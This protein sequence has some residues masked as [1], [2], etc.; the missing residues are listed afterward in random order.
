MELPPPAEFDWDS[1]INIFYRL[2]VGSQVTVLALK[3]AHLTSLSWWL[4]LSPIIAF[5][6]LILAL[7]IAILVWIVD[8]YC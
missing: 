6:A 8:W 7:T 5:T 1:I 4:V 3:L 2:V